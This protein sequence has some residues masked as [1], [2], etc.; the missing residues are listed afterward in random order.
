MFQ[1]CGDTGLGLLPGDNGAF[2]AKNNGGGYTGIGGGSYASPSI[3]GI[4]NNHQCYSKLVTYSLVGSACENQSVQ[5]EQMPVSEW[6]E[7]LEAQTYLVDGLS[8]NLPTTSYSLCNRLIRDYILVVNLCEAQVS[9]VE[10]NNVQ[11]VG[12]HQNLLIDGEIYEQIGTKEI[13][14]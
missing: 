11:P 10:Q 14:R 9:V 8:V 5:L 12:S 4:K 3:D 6:F 2:K 7:M 1:N 13:F